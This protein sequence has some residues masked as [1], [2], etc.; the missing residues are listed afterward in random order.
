[1]AWPVANVYIYAIVMQIHTFIQDYDNSQKKNIKI[2][3][4]ATAGAYSEIRFHGRDVG[5]QRRS[6]GAVARRGS[7]GQ[8]AISPPALAPT[9]Q[10]VAVGE[11]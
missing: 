2:L 10:L 1:M 3:M 7:W 9:N 6:A 4:G 11:D 8:Y 5:P